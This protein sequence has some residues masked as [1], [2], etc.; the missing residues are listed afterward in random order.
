[1]NGTEL[2]TAVYND[3]L[4]TIRKYRYSSAEQTHS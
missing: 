3:N 4:T 2:R 1:L